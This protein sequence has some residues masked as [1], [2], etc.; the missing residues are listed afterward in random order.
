MLFSHIYYQKCKFYKMNG[1]LSVYSSLHRDKIRHC[2]AL[3]A[4]VISPHQ[5]GGGVE[6]GTRPTRWWWARLLRGQWSQTPGGC[7]SR[8]AG[9]SN[10]PPP[11]FPVHY[12]VS[13][14]KKIGHNKNSCLFFAP[15]LFFF[16]MFLLY[17][18]S[19]VNEQNIIMVLI[20]SCSRFWTKS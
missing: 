19:T 14:E 20:S 1:L 13:V 9:L 2:D 8:G 7:L 4:G 11:T 15:L 3:H 18:K 6:P 10:P 12:A 16:K 5:P 17:K